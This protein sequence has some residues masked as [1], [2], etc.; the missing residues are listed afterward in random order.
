[1]DLVILLV[2]LGYAGRTTARKRRHARLCAR[3]DFSRLPYLAAKELFP[4][5]LTVW[6]D[7]PGSHEVTCLT[8]EF[9]TRV[10]LGSLDPP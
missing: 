7:D 1:V 2:L 9:V 6:E 10:M 8:D 5:L 4:A 3:E